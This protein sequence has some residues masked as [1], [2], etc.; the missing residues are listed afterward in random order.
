MRQ[1]LITQKGSKLTLWKIVS[2]RLDLLGNTGIFGF[3]GN[4]AVVDAGGG[5]N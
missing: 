3:G 1:F 4:G 2:G 5:L